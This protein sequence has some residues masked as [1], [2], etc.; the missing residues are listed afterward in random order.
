MVSLTHAAAGCRDRIGAMRPEETVQD[1][2]RR[3]AGGRGAIGGA[4]RFHDAL[5]KQLGDWKGR[6]REEMVAFLRAYEPDPEDFARVALRRPYDRYIKE[7]YLRMVLKNQTAHAFADWLQARGVPQDVAR[8]AR[9]VYEF[10]FSIRD[11]A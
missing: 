5:E 11:P 3:F 4:V 7:A 2:W 10:D 9:A 1:F 6:I 8:A